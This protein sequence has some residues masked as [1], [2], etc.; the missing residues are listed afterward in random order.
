MYE[1]ANLTFK[2]LNRFY[3]LKTINKLYRHASAKIISCGSTVV[4]CQLI[5][6]RR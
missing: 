5:G 1:Y 4:V 6:L 3:C 2:V